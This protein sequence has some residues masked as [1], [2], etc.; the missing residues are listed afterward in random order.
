MDVDLLRG[1][2]RQFTAR[3]EA[4]LHAALIARNGRLVYER[5]FTG[6]DKALA[7]PLGQ[8]AYNST[9]KH[10]LRS[11]TKSITSLLVGIAIDRCWID[12]LEA[13]VL[14]F[15]PE[16]EDLRTPEK[17]WITLRHLLTM[18]AGFAWSEH[19]P[20]SNPKNSERQMIDAPDQYRY[21]LEQPIARP[22][23]VTYT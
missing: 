19:L 18:S 3:K 6:E 1:P 23:G 15:F 16:Y 22:S 11:V 12:D 5:Y 8:V 10:D 2:G 14:G 9:L 17:D 20:Y 21:V 4:N 13:P 7:T